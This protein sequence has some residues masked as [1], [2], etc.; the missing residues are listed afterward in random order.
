[1][2]SGTCGASL[3]IVPYGIE[4]SFPTSLESMV[5]LLLIVPYGIETSVERGVFYN[6]KA[7]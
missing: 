2:T 5:Y 6:S 1:M 4:T 7:F 3:L